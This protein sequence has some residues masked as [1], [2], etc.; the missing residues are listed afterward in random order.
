[1]TFPIYIIRT[2]KMADSMLNFRTLT[3]LAINQDGS[4][5]TINFGAVKSMAW[6]ENGINHFVLKVS[7]FEKPINVVGI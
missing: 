4:S 3:G 7:A 6:G 2:E 1:M 5:E